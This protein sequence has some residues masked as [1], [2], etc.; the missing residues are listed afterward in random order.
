MWK[1]QLIKLELSS[2]QEKK[3]R[4]SAFSEHRKKNDREQCIKKQQFNC[5][6]LKNHAHEIVI[7]N[8][9]KNFF[10]SLMITVN[11]NSL[12]FC[13]FPFAVADNVVAGSLAR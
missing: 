13:N 10:H 1:K 5:C 9:K 3:L 2:P 4:S 7:K 6:A 8:W 11:N 12:S